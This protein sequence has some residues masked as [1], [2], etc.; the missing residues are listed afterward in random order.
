[1][2]S[3]DLGLLGIDETLGL[4]V[5]GTYETIGQTNFGDIDVNKSGIVKVLNDE[6]KNT[7]VCHT[8]LDDI[9]GV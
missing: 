9:V 4:D 6:G 5:A 1:M 2:I 7:G 3:E 8:F